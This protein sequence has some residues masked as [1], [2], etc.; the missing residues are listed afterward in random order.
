MKTGWIQFSD[1]WYHFRDDGGCS[2]PDFQGISVGGPAAGW[3]HF[4]GTA[5]NLLNEMESGNVVFFNNLFWASP[6]YVSYLKELAERDRVT[7]TPTNTLTPG[8]KIDWSNATYD[9]DYDD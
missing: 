1:G 3:I 2:N 5:N 8:L 6:E 9:E 7:R 4:N